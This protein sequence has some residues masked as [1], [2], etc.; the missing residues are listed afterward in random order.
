MILGEPGFSVQPA[1]LS[2]LDSSPFLC[3]GEGRVLLVDQGP[4]IPTWAQVRPLMPPG[5]RPFELARTAQGG[6]FSPHPF[7]KERA[8]EGEGLSYHPLHVFRSLSYAAAGLLV[9]CW[10]LWAWYEKN[11]FCGRCASPL[12]PDGAERALRC[13]HCGLVVYPTIAPAVIVA[14]TSGDK[15]LLARSAR[16]SFRHFSLIS[17]YV[18]VGE[19]LEH[20]ARREVMEEVGLRLGPLRYLGDQPWGISGSQ[21]FAF[22]AEVLGDGQIRLQKSELAEARWVRRSELE[23]Q[24]HT[25]SIAFELMERFRTGTL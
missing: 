25:V 24:G 2:P 8:G 20:A 7:E 9:S 17:G 14:I 18:E 21:M 6:V 1:R 11:R 3:F 19:T 22:Q 13:P 15:I 10:H 5:T 16:S 4:S 23:P 12:A